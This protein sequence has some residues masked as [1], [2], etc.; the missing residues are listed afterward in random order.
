MIVIHCNIGCIWTSFS[1]PD[2][3]VLEKNTNQFSITPKE[4]FPFYRNHTNHQSTA[5]AD[6]FLF[7]DMTYWRRDAC[8]PKICNYAYLKV[9]S[10][11]DIFWQFFKGFHFCYMN[12]D[13]ENKYW[14][15]VVWGFQNYLLYYLFINYFNYSF[16]I[17]WHKAQQ[18][19][20]FYIWLVE[21]GDWHLLMRVFK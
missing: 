17:Y 1:F 6:R 9:T 2:W 20:Y 5:S 10:K 18:N 14:S 7:L 13:E 4:L 11:C 12:I 16:I 8:L 15:C 19:I 21:M 3:I